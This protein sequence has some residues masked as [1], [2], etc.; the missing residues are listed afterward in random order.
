MASDPRVLIDKD[1]RLPD[2]LTGDANKIVAVSADETSYI[3]SQFISAS[4]ITGQIIMWPLDA[5]PSGYLICNGAQYNVNDYSALGQLLGGVPGGQFNVPDL[6]DRFP[7]GS[8]GAATNTQE[9]EEVGPHN[10][11]ADSAAIGNHTHGINSA[12]GHTHTYRSSLNQSASPASG[13]GAVVAND[14]WPTYNTSS[15]GAHGHSMGGAGGHDH[16]VTVN[17]NTGTKNQPACTLIN[18]CIKT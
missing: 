6:T 8:G 18:F 1:K 3:H 12:G 16:A 17:A 7:K 14:N 11:A 5:P 13:S 10:H 15:A 2:T 9:N 4:D